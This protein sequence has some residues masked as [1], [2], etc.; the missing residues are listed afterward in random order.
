MKQFIRVLAVFMAIILEAAFFVVP[1]HAEQPVTD[2]IRNATATF[3]DVLPT[4]DASQTNLYDVTAT[5]NFLEHRVDDPNGVEIHGH[6]VSQFNLLNTGTFTA[7]SLDP[8]FPDASGHLTTMTTFNLTQG[9]PIVGTTVLTLQVD[10]ANGESYT[11]HVTFHTTELP[12][13]TVQDAF[14]CHDT[15]TT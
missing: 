7:T 14:Q 8:A 1:A 10:Y 4:C 6:L 3:V 5:F 13:G 11:F 12:D 9:N 2:T 15:A